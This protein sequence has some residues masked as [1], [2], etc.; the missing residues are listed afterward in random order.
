VRKL[1]CLTIHHT[2]T[3]SGDVERFRR[4]HMSRK[5]I[6]FT[7][8]GYHGL[9]G[10]GRGMVDG[11]FQQG[12]PDEKVGA[13][14]NDAN[15]GK[16]HICLVGNFHKPDAGYTGPPSRAQL[17]ALGEWLLDRNWRYAGRFARPA[18]EVAGHNEV[19]LKSHP[20][21]CPGSEFPMGVVRR[22]FEHYAMVWRPGERPTV[23]LGEFVARGGTFALLDE[24]TR[25]TET[26]KVLRVEYPSGLSV[27]VPRDDW[28][29]RG[30]QTW[31]RLRPFCAAV[32]AE[33]EPTPQGPVV[34]VKA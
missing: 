27:D 29:L 28:E 26:P 12:R 17:D 2:A 14:V 31:V 15:T 18:L 25:L 9:I 20:T 11:E 3:A 22:W 34:R 30:G 4:E 1:D 21:A 16:L 10:N 24:V 33:V 23:T 8:I 6:P 7:D 32:G 19:A 5:P 13:G